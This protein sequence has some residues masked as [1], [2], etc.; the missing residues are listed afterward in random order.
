M[1]FDRRKVRIGVG[2]SFADDGGIGRIVLAACVRETIGDDE[3]GRHQAHCVTK[4]LEL[5]LPVVC[6]LAR[7]HAVD[8]WWRDDEFD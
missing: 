8:A 5:S 1:A 7:F 3:L 2:E 6:T 4:R